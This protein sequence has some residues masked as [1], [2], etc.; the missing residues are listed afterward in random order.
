MLHLELLEDRCLMA[1]S[2]TFL[3]SASN[4]LLSGTTPGNTISVGAISSDVAIDGTD[5]GVPVASVASA[6][7]T[8]QTSADLMSIQ[9]Q[10]YKMTL[11]TGSLYL[12]AST[13]SPGT[14]S[15][16]A[17]TITGT[18]G[19]GGIQYVRMGSIEFVS[20]LAG[21]S[22]VNVEQT[23]PHGATP[24]QIDGSG[25]TLIAPNVANT[26]NLS[27]NQS[28]TV[29]GASGSAI[30]FTGIPDVKGGSSTDDFVY[31]A[32]A[33]GFTINGGPGT[34]TLDVSAFSANAVLSITANNAGN[35]S[36]GGVQ[37]TSW[38]SLQNYVL[39]NGSNLIALAN[40]CGISG[41]LNAGAS[42]ANTISYAAYAGPMGI[43][44]KN[45]TGSNIGGGI[46]F[47]NGASSIQ[48]VIGA[49]GH[50]YIIGDDQVGTLQG[51][52]N[53]ANE[54]IVGGPNDTIIW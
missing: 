4:V 1:V 11:I 12:D 51:N 18:T 32:S 19:Q 17:A 13:Q 15:F 21:G 20:P 14:F 30:T 35:V 25:D 50:D 54:T 34:N 26:W 29:I 16:T 27:G 40:N 49:Q 41:T 44:L 10:P 6:R 22:V 43:N 28:G 2:Y 37:L 24:L 31:G 23:V 8:G 53:P 36:Y 5:T 9:W 3:D 45:G 33:S 39:G 52:G 42:G 48:S 46:V 38:V 47:V 7:L